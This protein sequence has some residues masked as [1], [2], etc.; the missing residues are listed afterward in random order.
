M[1]GRLTWKQALAW[2]MQRQLVD[3]I[4]R[5][6]AV[7]TVRRL[8]GVQAQ[9]PS[10]TELC[11]AL[12]RVGGHSGDLA[13]AVADG[14][15]IRTWAMRGTLHLLAAD[16]AGAVLATIAGTRPWERPAWK[17]WAGL[18]PLTL[19]RYREA[20]AQALADGPA[21]REELAA[22]LKGRRGLGGIRAVMTESWGTILKPLAWLGD[23]SIGPTRD[24]HPTFVSP[25]R[26]TP[27]WRPLPAFEEAAPRV[28]AAYFA[29]YGPAPKEAFARWMGEGWFGKRAL[30]RIVATLGE[31]LV[32]LEVEGE[33]VFAL[34]EDSEALHATAPS[35][36]I[37][38][39]PGF[40][41]WVLGP[42]TADPHVIP[43]SRRREVSRQSGWI[44][45][46]ILRGGVVSGT[47]QLRDSTVELTVWPEA[48]TLPTR[49]LDDEVA[50]L[51]TIV[52]R[53]LEVAVAKA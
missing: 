45:P 35:S 10:T 39:L 42:G 15:L 26:A 22:A 50:R 34:A 2:R 29:A 33:T 31:R 4:G 14:R 12:R 24:G 53:P 46:V 20:V 6:S 1:A 37:R 21:T 11:V 52:G 23:L 49:A 3:P 19:E 16:E 5:L 38:L 51:S 48:G 40:D 32:P 47:W 18:S 43:A 36:A 41:Q 13:D 44:A 7:E 25:E 28:A 9:V 8:C 17:R 30:L 27:H